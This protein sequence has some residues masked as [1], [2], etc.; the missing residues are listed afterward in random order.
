MGVDGSVC[1]DCGE[2]L[3]EV[4]SCTLCG[5]PTG[6]LMNVVSCGTCG[7]EFESGNEFCTSCGTKVEG[8]P[9][10]GPR[11]LPPTRPSPSLSPPPPP[12]L[13]G[14]ARWLALGAVAVAGLLGAVWLFTIR[15]AE[16]DTIQGTA[17]LA[18]DQLEPGESD[19]GVDA[20]QAPDETLRAAEDGPMTTALPAST[21]TSL[22]T[23]T[24]LGETSTTGSF[25]SRDA[26]YGR[27]VAVLWSGFVST[28]SPQDISELVEGHLETY[29]AQFGAE[30]T[31]V[32]SGQF[33][34]LRDGTVAVI[35]DGGFSS[36][37]EAKVWC[38]ENGFPGTQD[39]FGVV[40]S[41]DYTPDQ[42]G[43]LIDGPTHLFTSDGRRLGE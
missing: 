8:T 42:R 6:R 37:R 13:S 11:S 31:A 35:Y 25:A 33:G 2:P 4:A 3:G 26:I 24:A 10:P 21:V 38:R 17:D 27:Y 34:S 1:Q 12:A 29:R 18:G 30:V 14:L 41:D 5:A 40:H 16:Q 36:A 7:A 19:D 9:E 43:D 28:S 20:G 32:D 15:S 39:C 22:V 23:S